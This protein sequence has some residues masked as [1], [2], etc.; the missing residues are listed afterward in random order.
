MD[1][2]IIDKYQLVVGLEIHAQLATKSKAFCD[3]ANSF[4]EEPNTNIS[5]ITLAHP[6]TLPKSNKVAIEYSIKMGLA[7]ESEI[8]RYNIYDRK[9]YF[10][11]DLPKG[12]QI[13][14][15]KHPIC[16]GGK[17]NVKTKS[18]I[19][20]SI[21][22][23]RI[24]M[25]EDA[26]KSIHKEGEKDTLI[27][28]NRAGVP[29]IEIVT[30]P[31]LRHSEEAYSCLMEIRRL[32]RY[33]GVCDGNMEEGS[34]R[35]DANISIRLKGAK[36]Y[37]VK[38]EV[39]NMNSMRNVQKAI[40]Y[41][42]LRQI[43]MIENNEEII[44]ET[45]T[46]DAQ[47]GKTYGMRSKEALNDYR[48]FPEPDLPPLIITD[49]WLNKIKAEMPQLPKAL[50]KKFT[51]GYNLPEYDANVLVDSQDVALFFDQICNYSSNY[52]AAS[53]LVMTSIKSYLNDKS[54]EMIDF[55]LSP[56]K[57]AEIIALVD[58]NK[59]SN[60]A[61]SGKLFKAM[62]A[63]PEKSALTVAQELNLIQESG[64]DFILPLIQEVIEKNPDK[65]KAYQKG[66]KGLIG[67]FMGEVMKLS[68]G[69]VDPK[70]TNKLIQEAL[71][72]A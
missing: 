26:G 32:V 20:S 36:E 72:K 63:S 71:E 10:Y 15:E 69:K 64:N 42:Q 46:F 41:E 58:S 67:M 39:K 54:I 3:D 12:F 6:G 8:N 31:D 19:K 5:V 1:K 62:I 13:T 18:G 48:Y 49:D 57:I 37:G 33:L 60:S 27:D 40:D 16:I 55:P 14:Q 21:R 59:V 51:A 43:E 4:G 17:I 23:N 7:C 22:L 53:N 24:H 35:C 50:F 44:S 28:L 61:A 56:S 9:N 2:V 34:M 52:K 65:V 45:R 29:L 66:K 38:V 25:E 30:E 70:K 47:T 68:K 11:P